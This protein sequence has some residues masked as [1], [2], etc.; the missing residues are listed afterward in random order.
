VEDS[1]ADL[2]FLARENEALRQSV[3]SSRQATD[4]EKKRFLVGETNYTDVIVA[5][6]NRLA[7]ERN[8]AQVLGQQYDAT[9]RLVKALG[10][11]WTAGELNQE[12]PAPYPYNTQASL[13]SAKP[14]AAPPVPVR[15]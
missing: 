10:G 11:G 9:V 8:R 2:R 5:D 7:T 12:H 13:P 6:E 4:L 3:L 15:N 14:D 1:L